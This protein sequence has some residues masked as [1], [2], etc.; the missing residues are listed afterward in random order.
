MSQQDGHLAFG[1]LRMPNVNDPAVRVRCVRSCARLCGTHSS[2]HT[3]MT[4]HHSPLEERQHEGPV[5]L[6]GLLQH[7]QWIRQS[8][9]Q[10]QQ[11]L[12]A[13]KGALRT[14]AD[15]A[16]CR[17]LH[18]HSF[19][20]SSGENWHSPTSRSTRDPRRSK[21]PQAAGGEPLMLSQWLRSGLLSRP[22]STFNL[23]FS[24]TTKR[25]KRSQC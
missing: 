8:N 19:A 12:S 5:L 17:S 7:T 11:R 15:R 16:C 14:G 21:P 1:R 24:K 20:F 4:A 22:S 2:R 13:K 23:F 18:A 3:Q 9:A 6:V 25:Q 10:V